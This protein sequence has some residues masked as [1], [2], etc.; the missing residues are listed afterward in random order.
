M[1]ARHAGMGIDVL[2]SFVLQPHYPVV[3]TEV[4]T[5]SEGPN[6]ALLVMHQRSAVPSDPDCQASAGEA[7]AT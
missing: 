2:R 3:H 5:S 4:L 7:A 6:S 1:H